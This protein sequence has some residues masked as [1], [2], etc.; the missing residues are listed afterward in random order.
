MNRRET[1]VRRLCP[2]WCNIKSGPKQEAP[3]E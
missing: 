3:T 2:P 1:T